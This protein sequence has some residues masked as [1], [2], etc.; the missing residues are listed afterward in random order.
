[1]PPFVS[2]DVGFGVTGL[3][4]HD[5]FKQSISTVAPPRPPKTTPG[6]E[7]VLKATG[8]TQTATTDK[9][10]EPK[11]PK[12]EDKPIPPPKAS[13][14]EVLHP[15]PAPRY[16]SPPVPSKP[17]IQPSRSTPSATEKVCPIE[18]PI[19][20]QRMLPSPEK[21]LSAVPR[22]LSASVSPDKIIDMLPRHHEPATT[23]LEPTI[24][25]LKGILHLRQS[26]SNQLVKSNSL[27]STLGS[28]TGTGELVHNLLDCK[29]RNL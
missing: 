1:M 15:T 23:D 10:E 21:P 20:L 13:R 26:P 25:V 3:E 7:S 6:V 5:C 17:V 9:S 24:N 19:P 8:S 2:V 14:S 22:R 18:K 27:T 11:Q 4:E 29:L 16:R 28:G 12:I